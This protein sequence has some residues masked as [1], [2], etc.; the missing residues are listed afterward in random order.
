M[1]EEKANSFLKMIRRSQRGR[2]KI[3][4][5]YCAGVGKTWRMLQE[6]QTMRTEG[7]D[8]VIGLIETHGR[9]E[10]AVLAEGFEIVPRFSRDYKGI[11][12][13]EMDV[14]A[15]L[16][17][18]PAVV[19][20]DELAHTN[21]PGCRNLKRY[22][23]VQEI[24]DAGIHVITTL[25]VQH[26][27]SLYDTVE[28]FVGVKVR[29]RLPDTVI[30]EADQ[31]VN[32]DLSTEDLRKRLEEGKIYPEE[33][34]ETALNHFFISAN[35]EKLRELTLRELAAQI[36]SRRKGPDTDDMVAMPDQVMV[37]LSSRGPNSDQLLRYASRFAGRLNKNWYAL[38]VQREA[39]D[40][41]HIDVLTQNALT[42][43]L[44]LARQLGAI[45]FTYKG[46][47]L[48]GTIIRFAR[49][50]H[51]GHII[52]GTPAKLPFF[53]RLFRK[54]TLSERLVNEAEGINIVIVDTR[55]H[56]HLPEEQPQPE[57]QIPLK[58]GD[59]GIYLSNYLNE[60]A[61][62]TWPDTV[63]K[64]SVIMELTRV[65]CTE[66][67]D[68]EGIFHSLMLREK[69]STTFFNE[70]VAFPHLRIEGDFT[71]KVALGIIPGGIANISTVKPIR[72]VFLFISSQGQL[73]IQAKLLALA[74]KIAGNSHL[75]EILVGLKSPQK[76][77]A[78]ITKWEENH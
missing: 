52:I 73:P 43:T 8:V 18:K 49:E 68:F 35:L 1:N 12:V 53:K 63:L 48:T 78:E 66:R 27:E 14:D 17:R 51:I 47:D 69:E 11:L 67:D 75:V 29:E 58:P 33:R 20:I 50:Y 34:I 71:P 55:R 72:L 4:F 3:Y 77:L 10:I 16:T 32:V 40:P 19:L 65:V 30:F 24:L 26:L 62:I 13:E 21:V 45:V 2:L 59:N 22:M 7:V 57:P 23:D 64:E 31:I 39:E 41:L 36:D 37:C 6:G 54:K 70:G 38:Y 28:K 9:A 25:N 44:T 56:Y 60:K 42:N 5:G 46:E 76:I 61:I 15:I 74:S